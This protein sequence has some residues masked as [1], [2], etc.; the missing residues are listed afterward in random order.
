MLF[1][2]NYGSIVTFELNNAFFPFLIGDGC[3]LTLFLAYKKFLKVFIG[4]G[5]DFT[6][7]N[8][9]RKVGL[10]QADALKIYKK[11]DDGS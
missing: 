6:L 9:Y 2:S 10:K 11:I 8:N 5:L 3:D 4:K 7:E 1:G